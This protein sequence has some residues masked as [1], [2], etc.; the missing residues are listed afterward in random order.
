[1]H[2]E[3]D[4]RTDEWMSIPFRHRTIVVETLAF[5]KQQMGILFAE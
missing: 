2:A 3:L 1:M 4:K 5:D